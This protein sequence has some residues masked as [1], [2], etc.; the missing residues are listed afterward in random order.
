MPN[1]INNTLENLNNPLKDGS[2]FFQ[3]ILTVIIIAFVIYMIVD[4]LF[5]YY[6]LCCHH[7]K[8]LYER[9]KERNY[10]ETGD[11]ELCE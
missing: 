3:A 2:S 1:I 11:L 10:S 8:Q 4:L 9:R 5:N 7:T 6:N